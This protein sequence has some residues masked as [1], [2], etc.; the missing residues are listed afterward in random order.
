MDRRTRPDEPASHRARRAIRGSGHAGQAW[1]QAAQHAHAGV[2]GVAGAL[3]SWRT[4]VRRRAPS[5]SVCSACSAQCAGLG[6]ERGSPHAVRR[7]P[8]AVRRPWLR[9]D[10]GDGRTTRADRAGHRAHSAQAR[11]PAGRRPQ[12][13]AS[14]QSQARHPCLSF[15]GTVRTYAQARRRAG[16]AQAELASTQRWSLAPGPLPVAVRLRVVAGTGCVVRAAVPTGA[17]SYTRSCICTLA[18]CAFAA[19]QAGPGR[20]PGR[21]PG[22]HEGMKRLLGA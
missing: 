22:T 14:A 10:R 4:G 2:A 6:P 16:T 3:R 20:F 1:P 19:R 21:F 9:G 18:C 8:Y 7:T 11:R 15:R 13:G 5:P 17:R 12:G